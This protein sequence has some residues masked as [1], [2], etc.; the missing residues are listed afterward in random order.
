M[1]V[2]QH[3]L[4]GFELT[5][6][7]DWIHRKM[8]EVD[9]FASIP[10]ALTPDYSG[11]KSGQVLVRGEFNCARQPIEPIWNRH[12]GMLASWLG[13]HQVGSSPWSMAGALGVEA[14]IVLP[15][16]DDRRL[17][18]GILERDM[19][20]LHFIVLH[21][22]EEYEFFQTQATQI[23]SSLRF[24]PEVAGVH[25]GA[26]G[27][28]IPPDYEP[29]APQDVIDDIPNPALW[30]AYEGNS[31]IGALQSFYLR[32]APNYG[33]SVV[34]FVPH[35]SPAELGFSRFKL[36]KGDAIITLG[37]MPYQQDAGDLPQPA[38]IVM[39]LG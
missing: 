29:V 7:D 24:P 23:I 28:P 26:E 13:A 37:L 25:T 5:Y 33:W 1:G 38:R 4:W 15:K 27:L 3:V 17:W 16:K 9:G 22:K 19:T 8:G 11:P 21:L 36:K 10:E 39:K 18:T 30:R 20:V 35:P 6:S 2:F 12:I 32:E 31:G 14:E 34:E